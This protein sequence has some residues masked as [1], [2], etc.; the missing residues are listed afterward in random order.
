[1]SCHHPIEIAIAILVGLQKEKA[2]CPP[3]LNQATKNKLQ[4]A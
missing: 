1:M 3:Y 4:L 2:R